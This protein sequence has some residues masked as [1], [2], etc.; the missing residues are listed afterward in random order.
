GGEPDGPS[1]QQPGDAPKPEMPS[2]SRFMGQALKLP[3]IASRDI[4]VQR[5]L[6][7][8]MPD[9]TVLLADRY[10]PRTRPWPVRPPR[11]LVLVRSP[12]GR[13]RSWGL[14]F[15]RMF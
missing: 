3:P 5:D 8:R 10:A 9:G 7:V 2:A 4:D 6:R 15:G 14:M 1:R 13:R 12:Y 11:P